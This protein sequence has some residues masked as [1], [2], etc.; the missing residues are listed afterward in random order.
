MEFQRGLLREDLLELEEE[1]GVVLENLSLLVDCRI[2]SRVRRGDARRVDVELHTRQETG[3]AERLQRRARLGRF[4]RGRLERSQVESGGLALSFVGG[5]GLCRG[6][7]IGGSAGLLGQFLLVLG[8]KF[9]EGLRLALG[10]VLGAAALALF[11]DPLHLGL[12][13]FELLVIVSRGKLGGLGALLLLLALS[14]LLGGDLLLLLFAASVLLFHFA[15]HALDVFLG[16]LVGRFLLLLGLL[17]GGGSF[18]FS[19]GLCFSLGLFF[20]LGLLRGLLL[21]LKTSLLLGLLLGSGLLSSGLISG[22]LISGG[23]LSS[24]LFSSGLLGGGFLG[25]SLFGGGLFLGSLVRGGLFS[26][27]LL[28]GGLSGGL[29]LLLGL[30]LGWGISLLPHEV[31]ELVANLLG[32]LAGRCAVGPAVGRRRRL[33]GRSGRRDDRR[34][35]LGLLN[36][37]DRRRGDFHGGSQIDDLAIRVLDDDGGALLGRPSER[38]GRHDGGSDLGRPLLRCALSD[39]RGLILP[40]ARCR[41]VRNL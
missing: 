9:G 4:H 35:G 41:T 36:R 8:Q 38:R 2:E 37:R 33:R 29:L 15:N 21:S 22:S 39:G 6:A 16:H 14:L 18:G 13:L 28:F 26:S 25:G 3:G 20:S 32:S 24:G 17:S 5:S 11:L 30:R 7:A 40:G 23:L 19:L 1:L 27:S 31:H 10:L 12:L 34:R